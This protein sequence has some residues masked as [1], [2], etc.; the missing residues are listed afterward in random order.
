[1]FWKEV[2]L[3]N[4][5]P[6]THSGI[7]KVEVAFEDPVT[8]FL[9]TN[10]CGKSSLLRA[11][12]PYPPTRTEFGPSG[13]IVKTLEHNGHIF[14]LTSNFKNSAA[15]HSFK[16]DDQELNLSGTTETQKDL[17]E[18]HFGITPLLD[19]IMSGEVKICSMS[20]V[21]RKA[22]F[23]S[24][25]PSDLSFVL[26]YHKQVCSTSR[27]YANQLKLLKTREA[28]IRSS[29]MDENEVKKL[30]SFVA[31]ATDLVKKID[32]CIIILEEQNRK[33]QEEYKRLPELHYDYP[34]ED[35]CKIGKAVQDLGRD[36]LRRIR[37]L[38][39]RCKG[40]RSLDTLDLFMYARQ[41]KMTVDTIKGRI[42][43]LT[44]Q[45]AD[46]SS[47]LA[48][49]N[50]YKEASTSASEKTT[51][52][53]RYKRCAEEL[54]DVNRHLGATAIAPLDIGSVTLIENELMPMVMRWVE[55]FHSVSERVMP[56]DKLSE[57]G[58]RLE[59]TRMILR[60]EI[61]QTLSQIAQ[62]LTTVEDRLNRLTSR[63]YP[64]DCTAVCQLR[65][66]VEE[67]IS[68]ARTR[69]AELLDRRDRV[70]E[71][72]QELYKFVNDNS[73]IFDRQTQYH[74]DISRLVGW[75]RQY[76][77]ENVALS[78]EDPVECCNMHCSDIP[79]RILKACEQTRYVVRRDELNAEIT[80]I[81]K[82]LEKLAETKQLQMSMDLIETTI[83][84]KETKINL[85]ADELIGL[86]HR[87]DVEAKLAEEF[88]DVAALRKKLGDVYLDS[89]VLLNME[90]IEMITQFNKDLI[91]D[92]ESAK[93]DINSELFSVNE[94]VSNRQKYISILE[95]E[96]I[97]TTQKVE[98]NK[99]L[100]DV[101]ADG[102]SPNNGLPCIYLM[103]FINRLISRANKIIS[104]VWMYGMEL[105]YLTEGD[106]LDFN[107]QV[108]IRGNTLVKDL[109]TLSMGQQTI[110]NLAMTLAL[111]MERGLLDWM[112]LRLDEVDGPLTDEH[113]TRLVCMLSDLVDKGTV[114]QLFLVNHF[115]MQTG[116]SQCGSICLGTDG[117]ITPDVYNVHATIE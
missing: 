101:I 83:K 38:R 22:L 90:R 89:E 23:S 34:L 5:L 112:A 12:T 43:S 82:T 68:A 110:V 88:D 47:E 29:L 55:S 8:A 42:E 96:I 40:V 104:H 51:L 63:A 28:T 26:E 77:V 14:E 17:I 58:I 25:Y 9:G 11:L 10:G 76:G 107:I 39:S 24:M 15:P 99:K 27:M 67:S 3:Y 87:L 45:I 4:Y 102:L 61:G 97:P 19:K 65:S 56:K 35:E 60:D 79:N 50:A 70:N 93:F 73:P 85:D 108:R 78:G 105:V 62:E 98:A 30:E 117:I 84:D 54:A 32:K 86:E 81:H 69:K 100:Y 21:E 48:R 111:C 18:E 16:K 2:A 33:Y 52:E 20:K 53:E 74:I 71:Q 37:S 64:S 106:S 46:I 44:A 116:M 109:A 114:K 1:M 66:T 59:H 94:I 103:R 113:R 7:K 41:H 13:K 36:I 75:L 49:F 92:L 72:A 115:A 91:K 57:L 31:N 95:S 80:S 6:F